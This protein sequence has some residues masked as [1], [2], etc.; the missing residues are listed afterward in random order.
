MQNPLQQSRVSGA[1]MQASFLWDDSLN[2]DICKQLDG[3]LLTILAALQASWHIT[4]PV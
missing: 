2:F 3:H 4:A 1:A